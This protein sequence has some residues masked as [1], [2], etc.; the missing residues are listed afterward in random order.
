MATASQHSDTG[1]TVR[2][3]RFAGREALIDALARRLARALEDT[4]T[5]AGALMLS[6]GSTPLP[7][8]RAL[9]AARPRAPAGLKLFY[10]DDR[11]VPSSSDASNYHQTTVLIEALQLPP[12][13]VLRVRTELPLE[14]A[15]A[16]YDAQLVGL[17]AAGVTMPLGLLGLGADGH[18]ASLFNAEHLARAREH[19]AIAVH[20]P[21]GREAVSVTPQVLERVSSLLFIVAGADKRDALRAFFGRSGQSTAWRAVCGRERVEVWCDQDAWPGGWPDGV[22]GATA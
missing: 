13:R 8:Y 17:E 4:V 1:P 10:S 15:A 18:T 5:G 9:A 19:R 12:E 7:A 22:N 6:G 16:D 20:R 14:A 2:A 21:D 11:Y 3:Q